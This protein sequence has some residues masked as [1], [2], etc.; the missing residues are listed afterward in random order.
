M[1]KTKSKTEKLLIKDRPKKDRELN[2]W[3]PY[4][5]MSEKTRKVLGLTVYLLN[6][7]LG[8]FIVKL[9][10]FVSIMGSTTMPF[11]SFVI[12]GALYYMHLKI[13]DD[14]STKY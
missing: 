14:P 10:L 4:M 6:L 13:E 5:D 12:P 11:I 2:Y 3:M 9:D 1:V 8:I 7:V